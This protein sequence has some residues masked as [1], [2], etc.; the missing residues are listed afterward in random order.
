[1]QYLTVNHMGKIKVLSKLGSNVYPAPFYIGTHS[2]SAARPQMLY[3]IRFSCSFS[4]LYGQLKLNYMR[5]YILVPNNTY[6]KI[7]QG[8]QNSRVPLPGEKTVF[9]S[10]IFINT[11]AFINFTL[12]LFQ[13]I[14]HQE[15]SPHRVIAHCFHLPRKVEQC[16]A[17][18]VHQPFAGYCYAVALL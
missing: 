4:T 8:I 18:L 5:L 14:M 10:F 15:P 12:T 16:W 3:L 13:I 1:M 11:S 9:D 6:L 17:R 2:C 7:P